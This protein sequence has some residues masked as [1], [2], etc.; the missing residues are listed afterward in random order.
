MKCREY[1]GSETILYDTITVDTGHYAFVKITRVNFNICK[2]LKT[3]LEWNVEC[4]ND[5][6]IL[7]CRKII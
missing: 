7:K 1:L 6:T 2:F 4:D 3:H 5:L